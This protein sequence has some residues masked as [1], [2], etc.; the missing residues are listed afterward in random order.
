MS[1]KSVPTD[2]GAFR[3]QKEAVQQEANILIS[4]KIALIEKTLEEI[5]E[6]AEAT[7][8]DVNFYSLTND[9]SSLRRRSERGWNSSSDA[10]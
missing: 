7:G 8:V 10:C 5:A 4:E 3:K 6:I 9:L 2:F 1:S